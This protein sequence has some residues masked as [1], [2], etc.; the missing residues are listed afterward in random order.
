MTEVASTGETGTAS[1]TPLVLDAAVIGAGV[2]GLYQLHQLRELGLNVKVFDTADGVGGTWYWNRYPGA[3][4][5]SASYIYQYLFSEE[6]YKGWS[7]SSKFPGQPEIERW[8]NYVADKLDL[9][10]DIQ[11]NTTIK[12]AHFDEDRG[13]W[14]LTTGSGQII[15]AQFLIS[16]AGML[17]APLEDLFE[18]QSSFKGRIFHTARWPKDDV[19]LAGKRVGVIGNGAT[20]IQVI[21]TIAPEVGELKV[22]IRTPQYVNAMNNPTYGPKEVEEY[23]SKFEYFQERLPN[24]FSGFEFEFE[25]GAWADKTPAERKAVFERI[26]DNGSLELWLA[27]FSEIFFDQDVNDEISAFVRDKMRERLKDPELC[28]LLIPKDYGFGL[29]RVPLESGYLE[30]YHLPHVSIVSVKDN[31][32]ARITPEGIQL[33]DGTVHELDVIIMATGFDAG[34]GALTRI[35]IRGRD[36]RSLT[37][38][39]HQ[40]ITTTMGLQVHGYPN[41]F[42]TGAPLAPSAALCNMTTCLQQQTEWI[43]RCIKHMREKNVAV[44][45]ATRDAENQWVQHHDEVANKT[46]V[47]KTYSWYMGSNIEGKPRRLLSYIGGV[48]AYRQKCTEVADKGYPGFEMH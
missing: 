15:D 3:K 10:R 25:N 5:D 38:Q 24:T 32:I 21:Q 33:T 14:T 43:T 18:G 28:E 29:H 34:S 40:E 7:W 41:L 45:E 42:T 13:R 39:W 1:S 17:S 8:M 20:G 4:F 9:R 27:S 22:F 48:G 46:L 6:L 47:S 31:P 26:W 44:I 30:T 19:E 11:F 23:H 35:D 16:C 2:A 36:G 12:S 37:E